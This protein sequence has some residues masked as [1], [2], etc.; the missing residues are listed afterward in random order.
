MNISWWR[1]NYIV[2]LQAVDSSHNEPVGVL[3]FFA[4]LN[5]LLNYQSSF[6]VI[7]DDLRLMS[8]NCNATISMKYQMGSKS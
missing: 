2:P 3:H 1:R 8:R 7:W 6:S 4:S 5:N